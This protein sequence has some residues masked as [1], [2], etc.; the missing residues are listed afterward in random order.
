MAKETILIVD[1][2]FNAAWTLS[3]FLTAQGY[4]VQVADSI[5]RALKNC[6]QFE[7]SGLVTEYWV[8]DFSTVEMVR[9]LKRNSPELYVMMLAGGVLEEDEYEAVMDAGVDD[10]FVK[11]FS[12]K[13]ILIHLKKGLGHRRVFININYLE[14]ELQRIQI[15]EHG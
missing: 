9:E 15:G 13:R 11:P 7:V 12:A 5:D 14:K 1:K 8:G 10:F 4:I 3:A 6:S 2:E